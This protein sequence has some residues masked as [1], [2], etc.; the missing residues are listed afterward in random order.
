M[1]QIFV[2]TSAFY[3][4]ADKKDPAHSRA[5]HFLEQNDLPLLTTNYIFAESLSLLTKRLGK[6]IALQ[7]GSGLKASELIRLFYLSP[8][9][10]EAAWKEFLKYRDK[11]FDFIDSTCFAVMEK[12]GIETAFSFDRHFAQR[13][14]QILP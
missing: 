12:Q 2:D 4:L 6:A 13:G 10:E 5:L 9:Y 8:D 1:R 14:F 3:A 11:D 7:F